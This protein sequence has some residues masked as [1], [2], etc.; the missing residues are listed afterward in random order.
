MDIIDEDFPYIIVGE[1]DDC[2]AKIS[3]PDRR[4]YFYGAFRNEGLTGCKMLFRIF[5]TLPK[6]QQSKIKLT[7][8]GN[9]IVEIYAVVSETIKEIKCKYNYEYIE[10]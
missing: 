5:L 10:I 7:Y 1:N 2:D 8:F 4:P 3:L 6:G 9:D